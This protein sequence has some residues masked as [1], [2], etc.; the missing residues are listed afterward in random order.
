L[1]DGVA[2][3]IEVPS[4]DSANVHATLKG[5]SLF[6]VVGP[7]SL[8]IDLLPALSEARGLRERV[9]TPARE[10]NALV[11]IDG[12]GTMRGDLLVLGMSVTQEKGVR[13]MNHLD[14]ILLLR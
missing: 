14:A 10:L 13:R 1:S 11:A 5:D 6:I 8:R 4:S 9:G 12:T 3:R 2:Y 7:E